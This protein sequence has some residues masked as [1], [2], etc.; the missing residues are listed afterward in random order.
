MMVEFA[1]GSLPWRNQRDRDK[2]GEV[3]QK[4][5]TGKKL[6]DG[7]P[8]EFEQ[9]M[10]YLLTLDYYS[11]PD[12]AHIHQLFY[13]LLMRIIGLPPNLDITQVKTQLPAYDWEK[14]KSPSVGYIT[15][16]HGFPT[17]G[18]SSPRGGK[19]KEKRKSA[20]QRNR[21]TEGGVCSEGSAENDGSLIESGRSSEEIKDRNSEKANRKNCSTCT[22]L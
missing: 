1:T 21:S 12:Y 22:L 15:D 5:M 3:K 19:N 6:T 11:K 18:V 13:G 14:R 17:A 16:S 20:K 10:S 9:F 2:V 4:Y 7:L 8:P